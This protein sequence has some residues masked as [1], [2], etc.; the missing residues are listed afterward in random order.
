[1]KRLAK[2]LTLLVLLT[3]AATG[4]WADEVITAETTTFENGKTYCVESSVTISSRITVSGSATLLL[5]DGYTLTAGGGIELSTGNQLTIYG[6]ANNSGKL[7]TTGEKEKA[8][9]GAYR[10]GDL[11]IYGGTINATGGDDAAGIG[12]SKNSL[13]SGTITINGGIINATGGERGAGIGGGSGSSW[14]GAYGQCGTI[15]INGGQVTATGVNRAAGI[16]P[17]YDSENEDN[18]SG[19]LTIR[20]SRATDFI[21]ASSLSNTYGRTLSSITLAYAFVDDDGTVHTNTSQ[22][23]LDGKTLRPA[24]GLKDDADNTAMLAKAS[25]MTLPAMLEGRTLQTGGW[26]TFCA[27][28]SIATP[29][30][31]TVKELSGSSLTD[32]TLT[33]TFATASSIVAGKPYLVKVTSAVA[34]PTYSGVTIANGTT[35]TETTYADFVPVMNPTALTGGD[36]TVLFVSGGNKLTYPTADGN[37]N[38][39]RAYFRLKDDAAA[40]RAFSMT[41]DDD[42]TGTEGIYD[43]QIYDL[44][45]A[46]G[47]YTLDGRRVE[48]QPAEK[49][50]YIVNGKKIV[51]K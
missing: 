28:F 15:V 38:A 24:V 5:K 47:I 6:E 7:V 1:M 18:T 23:T 36:K 25:G 17:G 32:G 12:G 9:I 2:F 30:G 22:G 16:G 29:T 11:T 42:A 48:G 10:C 21:K 34:N 35:T 26:N 33:L 19:S 39:F 13:S 50:V 4:A 44:R 3:S 45:F 31:W 20:W 51:V 37:I 8:G 41:F 49:G 27:P 46:S 43:L 40:A 14:A